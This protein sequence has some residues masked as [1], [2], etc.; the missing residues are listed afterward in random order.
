MQ[1]LIDSLNNAAA[2]FVD[3]SWAVLWQSTIIAA[4]VAV[5]VALLLRRSAP[6][7][8][9]WVWQILAIK[10]LLMAFWTTAIALPRAVPAGLVA[11]LTG[12]ADTVSHATAGSTATA[13][14]DA[15]EQSAADDA[16]P[17][18]AGS[19]ALVARMTWQA[20]LFFGWS[21]VILVNLGRLV[22]QRD[23]LARLLRQSAPADASLT[24]LVEEA[25]GRLGLR[26]T[27]QA[28]VTDVDCSPFVCGIRRP[29]VVLSRKLAASLSA[30]ELGQVLLHEL[31]HVRRRDLLWGWIGELARVVYFFH[32]AVHWI[33][34]RL[35]LECEL[36]CDQIAM[37]YSGRAPHE[38]AATLVHVVSYTSEPSVFKTAAAADLGGGAP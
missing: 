5:G 4:V 8:R 34:Y 17:A 7:V 27:P 29:V 32:P 23:R 24:T 13:A 21:G 11:P 33:G 6:S 37:S 1:A 15:K 36:A 35:R 2:A 18:A 12:A 25:A 3:R 10:I 22:R 14:R 16:G 30:S 9:Y 20:W 38:Y 31:A 19:P 26:H 28:V